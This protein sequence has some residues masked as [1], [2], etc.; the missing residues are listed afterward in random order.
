MR[1]W[2]WVGEKRIMLDPEPAPEA[3]DEPLPE[4]RCVADQV[5][6]ADA[7][8]GHVVQS[9]VGN[10]WQIRSNDDETVF[11]FTD[12]QVPCLQLAWLTAEV[13]D[14]SLTRFSR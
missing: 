13:A 4:N 8:L 10:E 12:P 2:W 9:W 11:E 1:R 6:A 14:G 7:L 5:A 3:A